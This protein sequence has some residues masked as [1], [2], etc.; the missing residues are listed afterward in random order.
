[1]NYFFKKNFLIFFLI[2]IAS[3][4]TEA[5]GKSNKIKYSKDDISNYFSGV[6][7]YNQD[8]TSTAF[9]YLDKVRFLKNEHPNFNNKFIRALVLLEKYKQAF[10]FSKDI[11]S[12]DK[13]FFEADLLLGLDSFINK[14]YSKAEK[15]FERLNNIYQYD[16]LYGDFLGS[17]LLAWTKAAENNKRDSFNFLNQIPGRYYNL[18]KIQ[19]AFLQCYFG[20][21]E[22]QIAFRQLIENEDYSFSR[23]NFFLANYLLFKDKKAEAKKVIAS[24][25]KLYN[26]N[27][28]IK[29]TENFILNKNYNKI[30]KFFS[31]KNP[32]DGIAEIFYVMANLYSIQKNYELSNFY[33]KISLFL[34]NK[35]IP[36]KTLLAENYFYQ[37]KY[38]LS[39]KVYSSLKEIGPAYSWHASKNIATILLNTKDVKYSTSNLQDDF[40]LLSNPNFEH[41]YEL[42]NF[43]KDNEFY[44][45]SIKYYSL[46]LKNIEQNH[47]LIS[48]ILHRRGTSYER[49]GD[50]NK[51][52]KD[53]TKSLKILPDQPHVLNYL[54]YSWI[55]QKVNIE[56]A[57]E[58][59]IRAT[60]LKEND[61]YIIDS[62]G[63]AYYANKN[64]VD[65][66]KYLQKAVE[67]MPLDPIINDHYADTLW[68]LKKNIQARYFWNYV[69]SLDTAEKK[70]KEKINKKIIFGITKKL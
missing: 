14:D 36:N 19:N 59:L 26:S 61:G 28:L 43:Y 33:L 39:K 38:K 7:S 44:Q 29:Q 8:Y 48:K 68:M 4:G 6:I 53:L 55:E 65:A 34:N 41:H 1:M 18:K 17:S 25:R 63:W 56:K 42:A 11:W 15:Y 58:M 54:A 24:A 12:E 13:F 9:K 45:E 27:L 64:Y 2:I 66:E 57:L 35:F 3:L 10:N 49:L 67:L 62:L 46:A 22:T 30:K 5:F 32:R 52:E 37:Q 20:T 40:N 70:L 51:A 50:W 16:F 23:Y 47:P 21:S 31:C 69:L 60:K